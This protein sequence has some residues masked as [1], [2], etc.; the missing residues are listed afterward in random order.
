[1]SSTLSTHPPQPTD[2]PIPRVEAMPPRPASRRPSAL[3]RL[4]LRLG[5][6]LITYGRRRRTPSREEV[7]RLVE[8][9]RRREKRELE[10]ERDRRLIIPPR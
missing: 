9:L 6:L 5:L 4:A 3:H 1:M 7:V 8:N 10:W 2:S